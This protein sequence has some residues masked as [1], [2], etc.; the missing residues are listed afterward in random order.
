MQICHTLY[1]KI[2]NLLREDKRKKIIYKGRHG[3]YYYD[4]Q[5]AVAEANAYDGNYLFVQYK[6]KTEGQ[7]KM[8]FTAPNVAAVQNYKN[9][10]VNF[11]N[12]D[13]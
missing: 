1:F 4:A 8:A 13:F 11:S 10:Q 9:G 5:Q 7:K 2:K 6:S 12:I 3:V